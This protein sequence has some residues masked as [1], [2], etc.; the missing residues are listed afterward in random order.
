LFLAVTS[1]SQTFSVITVPSDLY[2][3][4]SSPRCH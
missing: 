2:K 4:Q 3:S 1:P